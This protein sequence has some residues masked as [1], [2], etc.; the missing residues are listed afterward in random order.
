[1]VAARLAGEAQR[2]EA[3]DL[4]LAESARGVIGGQPGDEARDAVAQLQREVRGRCAH[5][6]TDVVDGDV[7]LKAIGMLGLAHGVVEV[8]AAARSLTGTISSRASMRDWP[9]TDMACASPTIH[10]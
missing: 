1:V 3:R 8:D 5:E 7:A 9:A 10:A 4:L 2:R 6:L